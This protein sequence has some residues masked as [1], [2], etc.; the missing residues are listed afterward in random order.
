MQFSLIFILAVFSCTLPDGVMGRIPRQIP[1]NVIRH[2]NGTMD[3][4][5]YKKSVVAPTDRIRKDDIDWDNY[6]G[7]KGT[8]PRRTDYRDDP[9]YRAPNRDAVMKGIYVAESSP[10]MSTRLKERRRDEKRAAIERSKER[11]N[12]LREY[13][14]ARYNPNIHYEDDD[15]DEESYGEE[16]ER[17]AQLERELEAERQRKL[18]RSTRDRP[19]YFN[20]EKN[21]NS[22]AR[23]LA[24]RNRGL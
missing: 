22:R 19:E 7:R 5:G 23:Q 24:L 15:D 6:E 8:Y 9:R 4:G 10:D 20:S 2:F 13:E 17:I 21:L 12:A 16:E 1:K 18:A 14:S 3:Q 11:M